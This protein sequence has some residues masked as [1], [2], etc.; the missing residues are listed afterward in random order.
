MKLMGRFSIM[1]M[2]NQTMDKRPDL[3]ARNKLELHEAH[4]PRANIN[5]K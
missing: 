2:E 5:V 3:I 1:S 4:V